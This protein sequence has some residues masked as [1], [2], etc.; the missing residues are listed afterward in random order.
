MHYL[1]ELSFSLTPATE[2]LCYTVSIQSQGSLKSDFSHVIFVPY[3]MV[4]M[5]PMGSV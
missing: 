2:F 1:E 5:W 3:L 4:P